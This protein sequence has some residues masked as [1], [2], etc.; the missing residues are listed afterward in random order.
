MEHG[1]VVDGALL[2]AGGDAPELLEAVDQPLDAVACPIGLPVEARPMPLA[3]PGR[4]H[5]PLARGPSGIGLVARHA[6][7]PQ[8]RPPAALAADCPRV[9]EVRQADAVVALA[10]GQMEGDGLAVALSPN[11]DLGREAPARAAERLTPR[12]RRSGGRRRRADE[13]GSRSHRRNAGPSRSG[14]RHRPAPA[15]LPER[16]ATHPTGAS[17]KT[18]SRRCRPARSAPA[19]RAKERPCA[20]PKGMPFRM[21]R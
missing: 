12:W 15:R 17:D 1:K 21:V 14:P 8:A 16:A 19:D 20:A 18:G 9:E 11:M 7:G 5:R 3:L 6:P 2:V 10:A 4:D 13:R